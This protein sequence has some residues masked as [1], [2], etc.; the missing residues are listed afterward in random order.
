MGAEGGGGEKYT[1]FE[2]SKCL[3]GGGGGKKY[4]SFGGSR[5][6]GEEVK[7]THGP[8]GAVPS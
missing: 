6:R 4:T 8:E 3:G 2:G 5:G 1:S 7:S